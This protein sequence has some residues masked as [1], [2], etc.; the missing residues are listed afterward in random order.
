[1]E[2]LAP[3]TLLNIADCLTKHDLCALSQVAKQFTPIAQEVLHRA[4]AIVVSS[5]EAWYDNGRIYSLL[6][7]LLKKPGLCKAVRSLELHPQTRH[8]PLDLSTLAGATPEVLRLLQSTHPTVYEPALVYT[9]LEMVLNLERLVLEVLEEGAHRG[10]KHNQRG[11]SSGH[12]LAH[13]VEM[14]ESSDRARA[15]AALSLNPGRDI[16]HLA[17]TK[18]LKELD[19]RSHSLEKAWINLPSLR[20]LTLSRGCFV[21]DFSLS[22]NTKSLVDTI[23]I[24]IHSEDL[25]IRRD[26]KLG[27]L[28]A[29]FPEINNLTL[30]LSDNIAPIH[31]VDFG[32]YT[33]RS[34]VND[35]SY[36]LDFGKYIKDNL[37]CVTDTLEHLDITQLDEVHKDPNFVWT[38]VSKNDTEPATFHQ[39]KT[40]RHLRIPHGL[41][42]GDL[43][44]IRL[45][46][47]VTAIIMIPTSLEVLEI[48][49][50]R[51]HFAG[52]WK[53]LE[54]VW[55]LRRLHYRK[56]KT[57]RLSE[58]HHGLAG[59][60]LARLRDAGIEVIVDRE[61][62]EDAYWED[63]D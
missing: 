3:E 56:L 42:T 26:P 9:I 12:P 63:D 19:L 34:N 17:G 47:P 1:M 11:I 38:L 8:L 52:I 39:F 13:I 28:L 58:Y 55:N 36:T 16:L 23:D 22:L 25:S 59:G 2:N 44:D 43:M 41:L 24:E 40:L 60:L 45:G 31:N 50:I 46:S 37:A 7:T 6:R 27:D 14:T 32:D 54:S 61:V 4:P 53:L 18:H 49:D 30:K 20:T 33:I 48:T 21:P 57:I 51:S 62:R 29:H 5:I 15:Q 35:T 10:Y